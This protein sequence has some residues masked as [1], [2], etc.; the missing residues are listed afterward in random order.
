MIEWL[1]GNVLYWHWIVFGLLLITLELFA[2]VFV[3]LWLGLAAIII[4]IID[5]VIP[6][7]FSIQLVIWAIL[8]TVFLFLWHKYISPKMTNQ[9]LAG[10]SRE[11]IIGQIGM[12][13]FYSE[14]Q[15]RGKLKFPA[16]IVGNDE[17]EFIYS[18]DPLNNGD[19][20]QVADISGNSLIVKR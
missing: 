15:G 16:P 17:W 13:V 7:S 4:G 18:G 20:V 8:S 9:T 3:M 2:P 6:L 1:D 11:A 14:E 19:K 12:V 5:L 10:L